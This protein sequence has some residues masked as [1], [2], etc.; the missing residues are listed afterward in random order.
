MFTNTKLAKSIQLAIAFGAVSGLSLSTAAL[1]QD[2]DEAEAETVE[3]IQVTG[4][5]IKRAD[6]EGA[7]PV[8]VI[9]RAA[10]EFSGQTS[11]A[12]L[13]RNTSFNSTGSFRP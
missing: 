12:D 6:M 2:A 4:S 5:R 9:D 11:V 3:K 10:I 7:L 13:L 1:A 8:T